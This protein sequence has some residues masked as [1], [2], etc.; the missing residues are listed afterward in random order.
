MRLGEKMQGSGEGKKDVARSK[1]QAAIRAAHRIPQI[2]QERTDQ[3]AA[4]GF[5][6][7]TD[8]ENRTLT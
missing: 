4:K 6:G 7:T 5:S 8:R 1:V 3:N 2:L